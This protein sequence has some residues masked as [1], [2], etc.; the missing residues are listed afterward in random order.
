MTDRS[1]EQDTARAFTFS[2]SICPEDFD[3]ICDDGEQ[4][5]SGRN[6]AGWDCSQDCVMLNLGRSSQRESSPVFHS[7]ASQE[8]SSVPPCLRPAISLATDFQPVLEKNIT[9]LKKG[10]L[11][12]G[13][14]T[15]MNLTPNSSD[16][17]TP[18][19]NRQERFVL[20]WWCFFHVILIATILFC[21]ALV[22]KG[23]GPDS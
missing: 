18:D 20:I 1:S 7:G 5:E 23:T 3:N 14:R 17:P 16:Q 21:F 9:P 13:D 19:I 15:I 22:R 10:N 8:S 4:P 11:V 2:N 6:T 12:E